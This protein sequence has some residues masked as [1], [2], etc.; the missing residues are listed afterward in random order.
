MVVYD[1][2]VR[3]N[4]LRML[5]QRGCA[6]TVVPAQTPA[7][8]VLALQ[9]DGVLFSNGPGD[10]QNCSYAIETARAFME[11]K[12][13]LFGISLGHQILAYACGAQTYKLKVKPSKMPRSWFCPKALRARLFRV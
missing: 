12:I 4:I 10:V 7:S 5:A 6:V 1:F 3:N 13:P 9:P 8:E 2:G 11:K